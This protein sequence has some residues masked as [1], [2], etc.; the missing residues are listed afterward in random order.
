MNWGI[1][2]AAILVIVAG[3]VWLNWD[4][5]SEEI[6]ESS[7]LEEGI[8][9][10]EASKITPAPESDQVASHSE[11][12]KVMENNDL[13][14]NPPK[15]PDFD[16]QALPESLDDSDTQVR[17]V[18][19]EISPEATEWFQAEE[20]V[21]KLT[22]LVTQ[23]AIGKILYQDR[24]FTFNLPELEVE[25][26][27]ER[28][29]ISTQSFEHYKPVVNVLVNMPEDK[30][31]AYYRAWYPLLE[32]AF[33]EL[34]L[35]GSFDE[36]VDAMIERILA[37]KILA[38]PIELKKP[39]SVTYKFLDPKLEDASQIDKWLWR[40]GPENTQQIQ[41]LAFRF[42]QALEKYR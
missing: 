4:R 27:D 41:D 18:A 32:Q 37:V 10:A 7:I 21:R 33:G 38:P 8:D 3:L 40:M 5:L 19:A 6:T 23:A 12:G 9:Q 35:P 13:E 22:L 30:L 16:L 17:S 31:V 28:Y 26:R 42:K 15:I 2:I 20:H 39:T 34:G 29:F 25:E 11:N 1:R 36:Q 14:S 24:P